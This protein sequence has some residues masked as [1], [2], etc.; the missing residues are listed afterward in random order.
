[1]CGVVADSLFYSIALMSTQM[2]AMLL[3]YWVDTVS[4][5]TRILLRECV[6]AF[7]E[8]YHIVH[9]LTQY[10]YESFTFGRNCFIR[11]AQNTR[12]RSLNSS[13]F[14]SAS[15]CFG[16]S[17]EFSIFDGISF[18][19]IFG[20]HSFHQKLSSKLNQH[21]CCQCDLESRQKKWNGDEQ[22]SK[23]GNW[24]SALD[25]EPK[26]LQFLHWME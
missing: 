9:A 21:K 10:L 22:R 3:F 6:C 16:F 23:N 17:F 26:F 11:C 18:C 4:P 7:D 2:M 1:M 20:L 8:L 13:S 15:Q 19:S 25:G 24:S 14:N 5:N 12:H